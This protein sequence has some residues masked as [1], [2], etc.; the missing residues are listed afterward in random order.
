M[1]LGLPK[2]DRRDLRNYA[3]LISLKDRMPK[4]DTG[5]FACY[6]ESKEIAGDIIAQALDDVVSDAA[7]E[8][9]GRYVQSVV[10]SSESS[11]GTHKKVPAACLPP[12]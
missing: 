12:C 7:W 2:Q 9:A 11:T 5:R 3:K 6:S 4:L 10:V 1:C 8:A